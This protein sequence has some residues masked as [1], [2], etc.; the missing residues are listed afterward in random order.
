[1]TILEDELT[2]NFAIFIRRYLNV[3]G[4]VCFGVDYHIYV[5]NCLGLFHARHHTWSLARLCVW[6]MQCTDS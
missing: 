1:M 5:F 4:G 3:V 6:V 2:R